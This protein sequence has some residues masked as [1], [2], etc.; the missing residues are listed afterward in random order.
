LADRFEQLVF[1]CVFADE[2]DGT[3]FEH[4]PCDRSS[5]VRR[6]PDHDH[7]RLPPLDLS[8]RFDTADIRHVYVHDNRIRR[9]SAHAL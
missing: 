7:C 5:F 2:G 1:R 8:R 4:A 9:A 3:C 6:K